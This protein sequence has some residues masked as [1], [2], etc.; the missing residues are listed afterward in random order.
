MRTII[1]VMC[2]LL[3]EIIQILPRSEINNFISRVRKLMKNDSILIIV[4]V[5]EMF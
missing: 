3:I 1:K 2:F 4:A 5:P